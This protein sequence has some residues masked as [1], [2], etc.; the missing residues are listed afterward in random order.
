[1][2]RA[3]DL[4]AIE[5]RTDKLYS[6]IQSDITKIASDVQ[7]AVSECR[8]LRARNA[9]LNKRLNRIIK[10]WKAYQS[11]WPRGSTEER[12]LKAAIEAITVG[13]EP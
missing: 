1:M 11:T 5:R 6:N 12:E 4:E 13:G 9:D 3:L 10:A 7:R 2:R 8:D